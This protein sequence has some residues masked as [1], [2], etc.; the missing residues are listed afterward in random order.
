MVK[1]TLAITS[2]ISIIT[3]ASIVLFSTIIIYSAERVRT[4][5]ETVHLSRIEKVDWYKNIYVNITNQ[6]YDL[7]NLSKRKVHN[8][9]F[10]Y[11]KDF[12]PDS[13]IQLTIDTI[14]EYED[15]L[16]SLFPNSDALPVSFI[17]YN[18]YYKM[19]SHYEMREGKVGGFYD[20]SN[21]T[22]HFEV[23]NDSTF[24]IQDIKGT[25]I[26]EY[27]HHMYQSYKKQNSLQGVEPI[28]FVEGIAAYMEKKNTITYAEEFND[29]EFVSFTQ[30]D[31]MK[32]WDRHLQENYS[33]YL[34]SQLF[35]HYMI[36]DHGTESV[37]AILLNADHFN[38]DKSFEE[39]M[40]SPIEE[41]ETSFLDELRKVE[42]KIDALP[43]LMYQENKQEEALKSLL[44]VVT[45]APNH[46]IAN[47][48]IANVYQEL[49]NYEQALRYRENVVNLDIEHAPSYSYLAE[50]LLFFDIDKALKAEMTGFKYATKDSQSNLSFHEDR[51]NDLKYIQENIDNGNPFKGYIALVKE[52]NSWMLNER[53]K[54]DL[55][56]KVLDEYPNIESKERE[57]LIVLLN[58]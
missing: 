6:E 55:I 44:E 49:G 54:R 36:A 26:H 27:V 11:E 8:I 29:I 41:Y 3:I 14:K 7:D 38:F 46:N 15:E 25:I 21:Q 22:I 16:A 9:T 18:D 19:A 43:K 10:Y 2:S 34:Q 28:W 20:P 39:T 31:A 1:N 47:H 5:T 50:T 4:G 52:G 42:S 35:I 48:N 37:S 12:N 17:I 40:G 23:P 13:V 58:E 45:I 57:Q 24:D 30:L 32:K 51:V 33:P 53:N 56:S